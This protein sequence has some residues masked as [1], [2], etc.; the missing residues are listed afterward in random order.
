MSIP[1]IQRIV[2]FSILICTTALYGCAAV[3]PNY[4]PSISN[5]E[6]VKTAAPAKLNIGAVNVTPGMQGADNLGI[7]AA[8]MTSP[9]G[10]NYGDY[11]ANAVKQELE[12]AGVYSAQANQ[13]LTATLIKN[14][15]NAGSLVTNDA[16]I[17]ARFIVKRQGRVMYDQVKKADMKWDSAFAGAV[18][19]P[20]AMNNYPI[21][22][23]KLISQLV[24]DQSFLNALKSQ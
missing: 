2:I 12:L 21:L 20:L 10:K 1:S 3:A 23:Q 16:Q 7:R 22:V 5:V 4:S 17:E 8:Q 24:T 11:L 13:E 15:I 14:N 9:I 6:I 18:A 19:I